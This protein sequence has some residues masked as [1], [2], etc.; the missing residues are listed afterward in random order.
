MLSIYWKRRA[1]WLAAGLGL[2]GSAVACYQADNP[3]LPSWIQAVGSILAILLAIDIQL[4][5]FERAELERREARSVRLAVARK[6]MEGVR[7]A[8]HE[9]T[10]VR[11][12][13]I[14]RGDWLT[15]LEA[16]QLHYESA[17]SFDCSGLDDVDLVNLYLRALS[18][19]RSF[20]GYF[21][22]SAHNGPSGDADLSIR[23]NGA[24]VAS[25]ADDFI[26]AADAH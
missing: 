14:E 12:V 22:Y 8:A 13:I 5:T 24:Q 10:E 4:S 16:L 11:A 21:R 23:V 18:R 17:S 6:L 7:S 9:L 25:F 20:C 15:T 19:F 3:D 26:R 2:V 1:I